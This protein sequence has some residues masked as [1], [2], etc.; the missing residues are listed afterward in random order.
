[1]EESTPMNTQSRQWPTSTWGAFVSVWKAVFSLLLRV[2]EWSQTYSILLL[3]FIIWLHSIYEILVPGNIFK[4][5][6]QVHPCNVL[7]LS[8]PELKDIWGPL[9]C[10]LIFYQTSSIQAKSPT[11][12]SLSLL[13]LWTPSSFFF[14][15]P[16]L[17]LNVVTQNLFEKCTLRLSLFTFPFFLFILYFTKYK[18]IYKEGPRPLPTVSLVFIRYTAWLGMCCGATGSSGEKG[19]RN[20]ALFLEKHP[21]SGDI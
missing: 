11:T 5:G 8:F 12:Q 21:W 6:I 16:T 18:E 10:L 17:C 9:F 3:H 15:V 13:Y 20:G 14:I 19:W 4:I 7:S 1:M 2:R